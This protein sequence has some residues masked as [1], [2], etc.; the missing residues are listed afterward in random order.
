MANVAKKLMV[1]ACLL[2][3]RCRYDGGSK[4]N[5]EVI[6]LSKKEELIPICPERLGGLDTP[7]APSEITGGDG[8][9]VLEGRAKVM[10]KDGRDVSGNFVRGA[11][12]VLEVARTEGITE[13]HL[14]SKSPSCGCG[15]IHDG[16][17]SGKLKSGD[18]VTAALLKK[19]G[20][21]VVSY[22]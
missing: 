16:T 14:K 11:R 17:F 12:A 15:R 13:A 21:R 19:N 18:G 20:I 6:L 3:E 4:P 8:N 1:S 5:K 9:D 2:G 10:S 7:R 22:G